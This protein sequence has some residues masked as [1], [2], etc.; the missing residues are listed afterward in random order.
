MF[1]SVLTATTHVA[2]QVWLR[3]SV[4]Y[5][6][7]CTRVCIRLEINISLSHPTYPPTPTPFCNNHK[8]PSDFSDI[9]AFPNFEHHLDPVVEAHARPL[10][11][12]LRVIQGK[13]PSLILMIMIMMLLMTISS[14]TSEILL[15]SHRGSSKQ[16]TTKPEKECQP[17]H[18]WWWC[19]SS[20]VWERLRRDR[21]QCRH[22]K[23]GDLAFYWWLQPDQM[24]C[25][26]TEYALNRFD[27]NALKIVDDGWIWR[28]LTRRTPKAKMSVRLVT[29][30]ETPACWTDVIMTWL[31][32][33]RLR[34]QLNFLSLF[35]H[36]HWHD[37]MIK[38]IF[39]I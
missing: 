12:S 25:L 20:L 2:P 19:C 29:V 10:L 28:L 24:S 34:W 26:H 17:R 9:E 31:S 7:H 30:I 35:V 4:K 1:L 14:F 8:N 38:V 39:F 13:K 3:N 32:S 27:V 15:A 21:Q 6:A 23:T 5:Y 16:Q 11:F 33:L 37:I 36:C 22:K 18:C